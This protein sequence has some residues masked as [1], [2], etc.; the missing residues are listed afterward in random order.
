MVDR[1]LQ[2]PHNNYNISKILQLCEFQFSLVFTNKTI[3]LNNDLYQSLVKINQIVQFAIECYAE[4]SILQLISLW[5]Q[6]IEQKTPEKQTS[7]FM[8]FNPYMYIQAN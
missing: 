3:N 7:E 1:A 6:S 4:R 8:I 2:I 5:S